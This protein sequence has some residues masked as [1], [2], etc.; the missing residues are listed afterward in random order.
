MLQLL[1]KFLLLLLLLMSLFF[2]LLPKLLSLQFP[3]LPLLFEL[4]V[5]LLSLS[6][7]KL[8]L[9]PLLLLVQGVKSTRGLIHVLAMRL[10]PFLVPVIRANDCCLV[11][12][13]RRF[14]LIHFGL[15]L[16][17]VGFKVRSRIRLL[18]C[19]SFRHCVGSALT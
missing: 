15:S 8:L 6:F 16:G 4:L 9:V 5:Q 3:L 7:K 17:V 19:V 11:A 18:D 13:R 1:L 2:K 14:E 12:G 10:S